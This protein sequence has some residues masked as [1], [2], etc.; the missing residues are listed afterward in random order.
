MKFMNAYMNYVRGKKYNPIFDVIFRPISWL[1]GWVIALLDFLRAHGL[2]KTTEPPLPL[3]SVGNIT[4]GGTNK[5]PFVAL[6]AEF[7]ASMGVKAGIVTRG[8]SG[9]AG[10]VM[11]LR[12]G[13]G[14]RTMAGDEPLMLSRKLPNVP[15]AVGKHRI[16]GV[17]ALKNE[18][19]ELVIADDAFQHKA[20]GRDADIVLVDCACPFG[21]GKI[22]PAGIMRE[23]V[24]ALARA[25]IVVLTKSEQA[26]PQDLEAL[27]ETV[28][29]FVDQERIFTSRLESDGWILN[30]TDT[31]P[32]AGARVFTFSAIGSP[33]S[34]TRTVQE[35][36]L[37]ITGQRKYRDHHQYSRADIEELCSLAEKLGAEVLMC[38]EKDT[39]NLPEN[40]KFT[41]PLA[42]PRV[43]AVVNESERF[44][45]LLAELLRPNIIVASNGYGEDAIGVM[46]AKKFRARLPEAIVSAFPLVG[47]GDAYVQAGFAVKSAP[48]VTPSGGVLK[49]SLRDL[50][51]DMRAGLLRHVR[52]QLGDWRKIARRVRTPVCVGD[53]YLLLHTLWGS[54]MRPMFCAAAKTVYLSGHWR[55]ERAIINRFTLRTW[56]RDKKSAEQLGGRAV[57][58][59]SPIMDLLYEDGGEL[60][61]HVTG[62]VVLLLPGSRARAC[63]DVKLLL[64][65]AEILRG[66]GEEKF[67]MVLA[68]TLPVD[69]F[70]GACESYG[71]TAGNYA[72]TK[73]GT[74]ITLTHEAIARAAEGVKIL[75]GFGGTAN[76]LCAGL[77]IPV[78]SVDEKGKRVQK[79]LLGDSEILTERSGEALAECA[80]RVLNDRGL[81]EFMSGAGRERMGIPGA[82]DD[83]VEYS[84]E[85][86]GWG[87]RERVYARLNG[88]R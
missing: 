31:P 76:Q 85:S 37:I 7:A 19:V 58:S 69:E 65:A 64:D 5:T 68:P 48:S 9:N 75:I 1:G 45:A 73:D 40:G 26:S 24:D 6:L 2:L 16:S 12:G 21:S 17:E 25:D 66:S 22:V 18:G 61:E 15:I 83:I 53:V 49:Y 87:V 44:F 29:K 8:Y 3:I 51:G 56:T 59:G 28:R 62:D 70:L 34:F 4:Y 67:R 32:K 79:K 80:L 43:K 20:L 74:T 78:I 63:R 86:L 50:W 35:M 71:W 82:L 10:K 27:R 38:T 46:L 88:E 77:G 11:I 54:G 57:Y 23:K 72:L 30:G 60:H 81:Y 39:Y 52:A 42:I 84:C 55:L 41:L 33:E 36:G 47:K 14:D 13:N